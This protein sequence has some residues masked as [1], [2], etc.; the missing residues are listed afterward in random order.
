MDNEKIVDDAMNDLVMDCP[1]CQKR[2][3][4]S[5][6]NPFDMKKALEEKDKEIA[7]LHQHILDAN[8][9]VAKH[10]KEIAELRKE[11]EQCR[12]TIEN[13]EAGLKMMRALCADWLEQQEI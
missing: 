8:K 6:V 11:I 10:M 3:I 12:E 4:T 7:E 9:A 2:I 1:H 13:Y 5:C